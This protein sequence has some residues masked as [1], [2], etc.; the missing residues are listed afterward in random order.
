MLMNIPYKTRDRLSY[1]KYVNIL[2]D[3]FNHSITD[4]RKGI[5]HN[6]CLVDSESKLQP[7]SL[8][9]IVESADW[10]YKQA[11]AKMSQG[12]NS[13]ICMKKIQSRNRET[14]RPYLQDVH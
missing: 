14:K 8:R 9:G 4:R 1:L 2:V 11:V 3:G 7:P 6:P 10:S 12:P 13:Q 5:E